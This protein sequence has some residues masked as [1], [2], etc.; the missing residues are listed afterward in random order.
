MSA[1]K[2]LNTI[3]DASFDID[4]NKPILK[5]FDKTREWTILATLAALVYYHN[6]LC[7]YLTLGSILCTLTAKILKLVIRQKRPSG[8]NHGKKSYGMPSTHASA[9]TYFCTVLTCLLVSCSDHNTRPPYLLLAVF[10]NT[11]GLLA[12]LSR[13]LIGYHTATQVMAGAFTGIVFGFSWWATR[14]QFLL[15]IDH[16]LDYMLSELPQYM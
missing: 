10:I 2:F 6:S 7:I 4:F 11:I 8:W 16:S 14:A 9:V 3:D 13:V 12:A 15:Y 5:F 1:L